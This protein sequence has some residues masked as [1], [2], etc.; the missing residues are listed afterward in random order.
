MRFWSRFRCLL[1][2]PYSS[3][4]SFLKRIVT[5][6]IYCLDFGVV[7]ACLAEIP[8]YSFDLPFPRLTMR[9]PLGLSC[10]PVLR[11]RGRSAE[12]PDLGQTCE[13]SGRPAIVVDRVPLAGPPSPYGKGK[14]KVGEIRYPGGS[15]YLRADVQNAEVVGLSWIEPFFGKTFAVCYRPPLVFMFGAPIFSLLTSSKCR[16]WFASLRRPSRTAS[17]FLCIS[18][19][20]ASYNT[21]TFVR[22]N[23]LPISGAFWSGCWSSLGVKVSR[24]PA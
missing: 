5:A 11:I 19:S 24:F 23:F 4:W 17:A 18:L 14:S 6:R 21:L 15:D 10:P 8:L 16:R 3:D 22:P 20:K 9:T 1:P 2:L 12:E 7:R 13:V